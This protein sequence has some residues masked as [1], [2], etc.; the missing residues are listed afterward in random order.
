[1]RNSSGVE[2]EN[3]GLH[4][5]KAQSG[6]AGRASSF[7]PRPVA[8]AVP[9][10]TQKATSE[11]TAQESRSSSGVLRAWPNK[12]FMA[13]STAA[14]SEEPPPIPAPTGTAF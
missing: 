13:R 1:M 9:P 3:S 5:T 6:R 4:T 14:A 2:M 10:A 7:S 8:R 12:A 11:P